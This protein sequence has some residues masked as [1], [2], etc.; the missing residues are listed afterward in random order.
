[1]CTYYDV[2]GDLRT[3][4]FYTEASRWPRSTA[5]STRCRT[6]I[7]WPGDSTLVVWTYAAERELFGKYPNLESSIAG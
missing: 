7:T 3:T 2:D 1:M 6:T 4:E 5:S